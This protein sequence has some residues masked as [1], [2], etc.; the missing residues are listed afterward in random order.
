M[1]CRTA[2]LALRVFVAMPAAPAARHCAGH[3]SGNIHWANEPQTPCVIPT[4]PGWKQSRSFRPAMGERKW[5]RL[6]R[7]P[8]RTR[9]HRR[10]VRS[11]PVRRRQ[12]GHDGFMNH[13]I[14]AGLGVPRAHGHNA[15]LCP[16]WTIHLNTLQVSGGRIH[17][18]R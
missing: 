1:C 6:G 12:S 14:A 15:V 3:Y 13:D 18:E 2:S 16:E 8:G 10:Q 9:R 11:G 5:L 4:A 17:S 7:D